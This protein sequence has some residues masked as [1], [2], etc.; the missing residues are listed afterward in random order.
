MEIN[1]LLEDHQAEKDHLMYEIKKIEQQRLQAQSDRQA[2]EACI[3]TVH[4]E[5]KL[6]QQTIDDAAVGDR[7][8]S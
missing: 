5:L 1:N 6:V 3:G 7:D 2:V 8:V 4:K